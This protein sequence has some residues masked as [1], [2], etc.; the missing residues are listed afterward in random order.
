M[1]PYKRKMVP[2]VGF[3]PTKVRKYSNTA[4]VQR[5]RFSRVAFRSGQENNYVDLA[6]AAYANDTT[7][8]ITLL[9]TVAQ[10]ASVNQ[11][12]GK[13]FMMKSLQIRGIQFNNS[14]ATIN[15]PVCL[16]VYDKKP[17][18]SLPAIT[19]ILV[20]IS[21]QSFNN[22]NNADRFQ[23]IRRYDRVMVGAP[24]V[25]NATDSS[26]QNFDDFIKLNKLVVCKALGTGA[27]ADIETGALY[28]V[29]VGANAAGT[30]AA[31][32]TAAFRIRFSDM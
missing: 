25:A 30:S 1:P 14:A 13:K 23:I 7:G 24:T 32:T 11:R 26:V 10:G 29:T 20:S 3:T 5:M 15:N 9:N 21:P 18:G 2:A 8:T 16:V 27:I 17:T 22:D 12:I 19:D 31:N 4:A 6:S 28:F